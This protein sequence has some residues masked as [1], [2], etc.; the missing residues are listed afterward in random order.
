MNALAPVR[1]VRGLV[2]SARSPK[3]ISR[4]RHFRLQSTTAQDG[5]L[6]R[7]IQPSLWET[8]FPRHLREQA[9]SLFRPPQK[10]ASNPAIYFIWIYIL[11]GSQAI[12]ILGTQHEFNT[13]MRRADLKVAKLREVVGKLQRGEAVDVENE[14]GTGNETQ[15][16]E[17]EEALREIEN[18]ERAWQMNKKSRAVE[19]QKLDQQQADASPVSLDV[20]EKQTSGPTARVDDIG[21]P[22]SPTFF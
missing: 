9:R 10:K 7:I 4:H 8:I 2:R 5:H 12:R 17:W 13:F 20:D 21:Q 19:Q 14:L 18:E 16:L 3:V 22:R 15:E 1:S 6:P 11:I